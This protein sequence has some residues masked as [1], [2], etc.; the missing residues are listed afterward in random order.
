MSEET[1]RAYVLVTIQPGKEQEFANE[2]MSKGLVF[3]S[4]VDRLDFVHGAFDFI[5]LLSGRTRDI[6]RIIIEMR[7]LPYVRKTDTLIPFE[8]LSW[9]DVSSNFG[10]SPPPKPAT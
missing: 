10:E 1:S 7:K 4:K 8:M 9:D 6:D 3:N 5:V 2:I